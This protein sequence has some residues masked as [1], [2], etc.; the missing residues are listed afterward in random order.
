MRPPEVFT[1]VASALHPPL[2]VAHSLRSTQ[3]SPDRVKPF[4]QVNP[5]VAAAQVAELFAGAGHTEQLVP[6][7]LVLSL[8]TH[9]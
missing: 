1:H 7:E 2:A 5:Q 8:G 4:S 6:H 3:L 9:V